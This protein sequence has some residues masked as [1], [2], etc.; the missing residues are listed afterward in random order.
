MKE[1]GSRRLGLCP[2]QPRA[3]SW[4]A[5][6]RAQLHLQL[7]AAC[8][9]GHNA[10]P[11]PQGS[12]AIEMS[13][14]LQ[15]LAG[16]WS[17]APQTPSWL[18]ACRAWAQIFRARQNRI[19]VQPDAT[20]GSGA[21]GGADGAAPQ[22]AAIF[23]EPLAWMAGAI[24][25]VVQGKLY[26]PAPACGARLGSFNWSGIT[27]TSGAWVTPAF[28]LHSSKLDVLAP[29]RC[30]APRG[31]ALRGAYGPAWEHMHMY[32]SFPHTPATRA[33]AR[34]GAP[35]FGVACTQFMH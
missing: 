5:A 3:A 27:N 31:C 35:R 8:R 32:V 12:Y 34:R 20:S 18:L 9:A 19:R 13:R 33:D 30:A 10:P 24:T 4:S 7:L 29:P 15:A 2:R 26:C 17:T 16:S 23:T 22:E 6:L 28:Q 14:G 11:A 21:D 1:G 25:G